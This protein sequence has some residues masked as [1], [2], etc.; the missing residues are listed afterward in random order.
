MTIRLPYPHTGQQ[1]VL[2]HAKRFNWLACGRRWRKTTLLMSVAVQEACGGAQILWCAPT[3]DQVKIGFDEARRACRGTDVRLVET[4]H[5]E[6][7]FPGGGSILYRSFDNPRAFGRRKGFTADGIVVDETA[8]VPA[9][10]YYEVLRPMLMDTGGWAWGIGT[11]KGRNWFW[12][13]WRN[14]KQR[15]DTASFNAPTVGA[16]IVTDDSGRRLERVP[17]ELENPHIEWDEMVKLFEQ[18]PEQKFRQEILAEFIEQQGQVFRNVRECMKGTL[19]APRRGTLYV[20]GIDLARTTDYTVIVVLEAC[21][22]HVVAFERMTGLSW[23]AQIA[24][25]CRVVRDYNAIACVD[26]TGLGD[27]VFEQLMN[28]GNVYHPITFTAETKRKLVEHLVMAFDQQS[29]SFPE[30]LQ[31]M[32]DELEA[33]E[34]TKGGSGTTRYSAPS[35]EHDDCVMALALANYACHLYGVNN[36]EGEL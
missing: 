14:E 4:P 23:S 13:E 18:M 31:V 28:S 11:P 15:G 6:A 29:I 12:K 26:K 33:Y 35:G 7:T 22:R 9:D 36:K 2:T 19:A 21:T 20:A 32:E 3:F 1:Y 30:E 34:A 5:P 25:V 16:R 24:R 10:A 27:P 8:E 17:H